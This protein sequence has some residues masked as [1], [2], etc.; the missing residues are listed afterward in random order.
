MGF[1]S[2]SSE[3]MVAALIRSMKERTGRSLEEWVALVHASGLDPLDQ[4]A[5]RQWLKTEHGLPQNTQ[6]TTH[7]HKSEGP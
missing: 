2:K 4:K 3:D 6:G 7:H 1:R 5:V